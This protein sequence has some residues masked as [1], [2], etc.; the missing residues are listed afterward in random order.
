MP[1]LAQNPYD[2]RFKVIVIGDSGVGKINHILRRSILSLL[3]LMANHSIAPMWQPWGS[4][5]KQK[6]YKLMGK[7]SSCNCGILRGRR[8]F[9]PLRRAIIR[10]LLGSAWWIVLAIAN[11]STISVMTLLYYGRWMKQIRERTVNSVQKILGNKADRSSKYRC[12]S[13]E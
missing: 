12:V 7:G 3:D 10:E 4:T 8:D 9:E 1:Q 6:I 5:S 2:F 11:L 13:F